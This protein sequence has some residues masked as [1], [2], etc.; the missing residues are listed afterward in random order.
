MNVYHQN[1]FVAQI[2]KQSRGADNYDRTLPWLL[3]L[4]DGRL[5]RFATQAEAKEEA[6]KRWAPCSFKRT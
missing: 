2:Y 3:L 5:R 1:K 4:M 6:L